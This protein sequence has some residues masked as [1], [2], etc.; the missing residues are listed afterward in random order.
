ME[1]TDK[2]VQKRS[3]RIRWIVMIA[4]LIAA[5]AG[6]ILHQLAKT[7][8]AGVDAL[9]PFGGLE[10]LA[11]VVTS[12]TMLSKIAL[13][14]FILLAATLIVAVV[15]R[16]SF[17]GTIC[18]LGTLQELFG[19][20]GKRIFGKRLTVPA[21]VDAVARYLK[22]AVLVLFLALTWSLGTLAIRPYDPWATYAH[23]FSSDLLAE[24]SIGLVVLIVALV[25]SLLYD[26]FFCK[27]LCPMGAFLGIIS[28]IG[29]FKVVRTPSA[30]ID[31]GA[32]DRACPVNIG[33]SKLEKVGS[34]EC[35]ACG[36]CV[37]ACPAKGALDFQGPKGKR[38]SPTAVVLLTLGIFVVVVGTT[39]L[40]GD[41]RWK[42]STLAETTTTDHEGHAVVNVADIRGST[43]FA[44]VA[45]VSGIAKA[46]FVERF[47]LSEAQF[48]GAI[49]DAAAAH[50]GAYETDDVRLFVAEKL[51][52]PYEGEK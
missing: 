6:T 40:T 47:D 1:K 22:Y 45:A 8:P 5:T 12:G 9:C 11:S 41:F 46:A 28:K 50:D 42:L 21:K 16:R 4:V 23:L 17:C 43:T 25:G 14:A 13:S 35:I 38:V 51:G 34:A 32:C 44:D 52:L 39:T 33:V 7:K 48:E 29:L 49:K 2:G 36:S 37:N 24:F 27:Y 3:R 26:R 10:S 20:L 31:C 18:P 15:F 19:K 30:C